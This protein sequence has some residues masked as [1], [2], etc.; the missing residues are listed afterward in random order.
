MLGCWAF[1][2]GGLQV[3]EVAGFC[4][5]LL[6]VAALFCK[7]AKVIGFCIISFPVK[8][9]S[10]KFFVLPSLLRGERRA[11]PRKPVLT[12]DSLPLKEL[13]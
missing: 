1:P 8:L 10:D 11:N 9:S 6:H 4:S 5:L 2:L 3:G 12:Q 7:E 13:H